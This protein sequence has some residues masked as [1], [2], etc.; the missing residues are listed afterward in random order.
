MEYLVKTAVRPGH[1]LPENITAYER[2]LIIYS[3]AIM[4]R[5]MLSI[6]VKLEAGVKPCAR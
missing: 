5:T 3:R 6:A 2:N 4:A 1:V